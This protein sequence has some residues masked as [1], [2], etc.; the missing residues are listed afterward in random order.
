MHAKVSIDV[1]TIAGLSQQHTEYL[2]GRPYLEK[3][4][5]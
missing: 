2:I 3:F 4:S 5:T 1:R